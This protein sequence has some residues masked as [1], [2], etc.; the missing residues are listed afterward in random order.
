MRAME[1]DRARRYQTMAELERDLERLLAGDQNVGAAAGGR[2]GAGGREPAPQ[3]WPLV[4]GRPAW[5]LGVAACRDGAAAPG[6]RR[7]GRRPGPPTRRRP[8]PAGRAPPPRG[9]AAR[10]QPPRRAAARRR[11][12]PPRKAHVRAERHA[13]KP[14]AVRAGQRGD[15]R[16]GQTRR[17]P[18]A[19]ARGAIRKVIRRPARVRVLAV[20]LAAVA[21]GLR[22]ARGRRAPPGPG[23]SRRRHGA[24]ARSTTR[25]ASSSS[26]RAS[27]SRR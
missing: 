2:A 13:T 7:A 16:V 15:E 25:W 22:V 19:L 20:V 9:A 24:G 11:R 17:A 27:T 18:A 21:A 6:G 14:T 4:A 12:R 10:L 8:S 26:T 23:A 5:S 3:R 1:K